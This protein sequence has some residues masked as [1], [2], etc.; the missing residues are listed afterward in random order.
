MDINRYTLK[1]QAAIEEALRNAARNENSEII[2]AH[3]L[4]PLIDDEGG[5]VRPLFE[6]I[7]ASS[8]EI[9]G[10]LEGIISALPRSSGAVNRN[11]SND[12]QRVIVS[13]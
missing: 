7:G 13:A 11:L 5:I 3:V 9:R 12:L 4:I 2:S 8:V 10:E 1:M 6:K